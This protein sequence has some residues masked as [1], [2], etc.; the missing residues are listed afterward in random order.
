MT[1]KLLAAVLAITCATP[2]M[3]QHR[4]WHGGHGWHGHPG[5]H[6]GGWR[7]GWGPGI[8]LGLG[9][10]I[11]SGLAYGAY[12]DSY[13]YDPYAQPYAYSGGS[14]G[15]DDAYCSQRFRSYDPRSGTYLGY[16][17]ERHPCP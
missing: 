15:R 1:L 13:A 9:A 10:G 8:A 17:G 3:A 2:A 5:W 14:G 7:G 16:D 6:G 11:A 12:A 4:G